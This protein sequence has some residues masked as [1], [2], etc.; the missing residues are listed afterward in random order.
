MVS[1]SDFVWCFRANYDIVG[2]HI[3]NHVVGPKGLLKGKTRILATNSIPVLKEADHILMISSGRITEEGSYWDA[4]AKNGEI[5]ALIK[6][7]K[8]T[9][10]QSESPSSSTSSPIKASSGMDSGDE[11]DDDL[12]SS[13]DEKAAVSDKEI[14]GRASMTSLRRAST[15]SFSRP[16]KGDEELA[17]LPAVVSRQ[18]KEVGEKGKVK[19]NVYTAYAEA[20]NTRAVCIWIFT[21]VA[22]QVSLSS[23]CIPRTNY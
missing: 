5:A 3:I 10:D 8:S 1:I 4:I 11:T 9:T 22:V 15:S 16:R 7:V 13:F 20:C 17:V 6:T 18:T 12:L 2:R 23:L 21:I 19:W 14:G